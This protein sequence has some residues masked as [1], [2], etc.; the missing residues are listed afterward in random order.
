MARIVYTVFGSAGDV[1]PALAV[2]RRQVAA[3]HRVWFAVPPL[4]GLYC[5]KAGFRTIAVGDGTGG[6]A[7][8]D[9]R[10]YRTRFGGMASWRR[11]MAAHVLPVLATGHRRFVALL[12]DERPDLVV[13]TAQGYWGPLAAA[14]LGLPWSS[15]HLYPQ[16]AE[17]AGGHRRSGAAAFG[18]PLAGWLAAQERRLGLPASPVPVADWGFSAEWTAVGHDP[19]LRA[20]VAGTRAAGFPSWDEPLADPAAVAAARDFLGA[21]GGGRVVVSLGSFLGSVRA[22]LWGPLAGAA[23][24]S[25]QR[26]LLVGVPSARRAALS[27]PNVL[28][29]GHLPLS[30]V[31]PTA[32]LVVHHGGIGSMYAALRAGL[33]ALVAP[34]A[35]DQ[36][37]N[38]SLLERCGA[39]RRLTGDP[40]GWGRAIADALGDR[41]LARRAADL[42][43]RLVP[44][45]EAADALSA[46]VLGPIADPVSRAS[47]GSPPRTGGRRRRVRRPSSG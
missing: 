6:A 35:F 21:A 7:L 14:E 24:G 5:R 32:D 22:D 8:R 10:L 16:L 27:R 17:L 4:L 36:P 26:F 28:A 20:V 39:G 31:L 15:L 43:R 19:A 29:L 33:P 25:P 34:L 37:F 38:A 44:A 23:V 45:D 40:A 2:A 46:A 41:H 13:T 1:F 47:G 11:S 42:G 3:G 9:H 12:A 18:G 30:E